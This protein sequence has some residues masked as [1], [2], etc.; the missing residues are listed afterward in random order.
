MPRLEDILG[1]RR[2]AMENGGDMAEPGKYAY[3][4]FCNTILE[5]VAGKKLWKKQKKEKLI[6][7]SC[8]TVSDEAFALLL[9]T[10]SWDKFEYFADN[11]EIEEKQDIPA[12]MYT[13]KKGRNKKMQ[14]WSQ[15]GIT[16]YNRLCD[17]VV[18][19]RLSAAGIKFE[20]EF[21]KYHTDAV[22]RSK[23]VDA[24]QLDDEDNE[25]DESTNGVQQAYNHLEE[26]CNKN[27]DES[28]DDGDM[29]LIGESIAL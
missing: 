3:F 5:C 10:N 29:D 13:E 17:F 25:E 14:G 6:S 24:A 22:L 27:D 4:Y 19:D 12:T 8:V 1:G 20:K 23:M 16:K 28:N 18:Q 15:E 11:P 2:Y 26:M 7:K 9:M 21:L